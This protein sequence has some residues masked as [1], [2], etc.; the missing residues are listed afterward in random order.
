MSILKQTIVLL[1]MPFLLVLGSPIASPAAD[2]PAETG[3]KR[4]T[5]LY[6]KTVPPGAKVL[7]DGREIGTSDDIFHVA[8]GVGVVHVE[9]NGHKP[10]E[11]Q[12]TIRADGIT[13]VELLLKS[14]EERLQSTSTASVSPDLQ[15]FQPLDVLQIRDIGTL[16][17]QPI[18]GFYLV[19]PDGNVALGPAYGRT[20]VKGLTCE[21]AEEKITRQLKAVLMNPTVQVTLAKRPNKW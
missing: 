12:V 6:V 9:L 17:D 4:D 21:Q 7:L 19:E 13:R 1:G 20:N 5:L 10:G 16:I 18:D 15:H 2:P 8:P 3:A 14:Q 11:K